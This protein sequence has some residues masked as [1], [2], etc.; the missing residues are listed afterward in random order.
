MIKRFFHKRKM[1]NKG[2][3]I[4]LVLVVMALVGMMAAVTLWLVLKNL[5]MKVTSEQIIDNFY[6][7]EGVLD[8]I[9][10]GL[11]KEESD[12]L[13]KSYA[14]IME[15]YISYDSGLSE[16]EMKAKREEDF[17]KA[18]VSSLRSELRGSLDNQYDLGKLTKY[19]ECNMSNPSLFPY[20][21]I[22]TS[23]SCEMKSY[24]DS[25]VLCGIHVEHTD[26]KGT[27]SIIDTDIKLT[28]PELEFISTENLPNLFTYATIANKG[29]EVN[30]ANIVNVSGNIYAGNTTLFDPTSE[31]DTAILVGSGAQLSFN[32]SNY[33]VAEGKVLADTGSI[34]TTDS[35][36]ELWTNNIDVQSASATLGGCCYVADDLS[37]NGSG[38]TV[39]FLPG[40]RY[41]GYGSSV[42]MADESSA[43]LVNGPDST[44][45]M[46]GLSRMILMGHAFIGT[47]AVEPQEGLTNSSNILMGSSLGIKGD[48]VAYLVPAECLGTVKKT[49]TASSEEA[50]LYR[51]NPM[52]YAQYTTIINNSDQ[53][54]RYNLDVKTARTGRSLG[55][56]GVD[57]TMIQPVFDGRNGMVYF[58]LNLPSETA[59][60][61]F[62]DYYGADSTLLERYT[63]FYSKG[64]IT[65]N[66]STIYTAGLIPSYQE[67]TSGV[68]LSYSKGD[69]GFGQ[70][71]EET[72][73]LSNMFWALRKRLVTNIS[74]VSEAER[75][76]TMF[77]NL[78]DETQL[79]NM[80]LLQPGYLVEAALSSGESAVLV[81][82]ESGSIC[83]LSDHPNAVLVIATGDVL[84]DRN[85]SGTILAKGKVSTSGSVNISNGTETIVKKLLK[86]SVNSGGKDYYVF[87]ALNDGKL[88]ITNMIDSTVDADEDTSKYVDYRELISYQ[89]WTRM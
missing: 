15:K 24:E 50:S 80:T 23:K 70:I 7:A 87:E 17:R 51:S 74:S 41:I 21:E 69:L 45:N 84:V 18:Y 25:I 34:F 56:Y 30:G 47:S 31:E 48:Q 72:D 9:C 28:A 26:E 22:T 39:D 16:E 6:S 46:A 78:V 89:N 27:L 35:T 73:N 20:A 32:D 29:I 49:G 67:T 79:K 62:E 59:K 33:V 1:N 5:H 40:S 37:L 58:Y 55:N 63:D 81:D 53:Y 42:D 38:S 44:L 54:T 2:S 36:V 68:T 19:V 64:I 66:S 65:N 76:N 13:T 77:L 61:Y 85:F 75:S 71:S 83:K 11:E 8:Q 10:S 12:A 88:Y 82:N 60:T 14:E 43:V 4:V 86:L 3:S 57:T 52:T